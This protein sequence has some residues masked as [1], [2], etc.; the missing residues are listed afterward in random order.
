L[1][2]STIVIERVIAWLA[3]ALAG[4]A[5]ALMAASLFGQMTWEVNRRLYEFGVRTAI[6]ATPAIIRRMVASRVGTTLCWGLGFGLIGT[7][8]VSSSVSAL[9]FHAAPL[10]VRVLLATVT[11]VVVVVKTAVL[12]PCHRAISVDPVKALRAE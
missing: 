10:D 12:R 5:L 1:M 3:A 8:A 9:V 11:L 2:L 7:W 6:G 4:L